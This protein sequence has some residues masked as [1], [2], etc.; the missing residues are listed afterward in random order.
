MSPQWLRSCRENLRRMSETLFP[1]SVDVRKGSLCVSVPAGASNPVPM[2]PSAAKKRA[3]PN[4]KK[5]PSRVSSSTVSKLETAGHTMKQEKKYL[6][7]VFPTQTSQPQPS[8]KKNNAGRE[9]LSGK[10]RKHS[11]M[12]TPSSEFCSSSESSSSKGKYI[13]SPSPYSAVQCCVVDPPMVQP[14]MLCTTLADLKS[15]SLVR[16]R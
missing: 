14:I 8:S 6:E 5:S 7:F 1:C 10:K 9:T 4:K 2:K 12:F 13:S 16:A 11:E 15:A 3:T